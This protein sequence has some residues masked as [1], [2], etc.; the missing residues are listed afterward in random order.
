MYF[1]EHTVNPQSFPLDRSSFP[2]SLLITSFK[3]AF[4]LV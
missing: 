1:N 3:N 2:N 4:D